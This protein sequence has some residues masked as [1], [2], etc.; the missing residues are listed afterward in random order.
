MQNRIDRLEGL[1]LSLMTN[2]QQAAGPTAAN[3]LLATNLSSSSGQSQNDG[4]NQ[5]IDGEDESETDQVAESLGVM[6]VF[7][8]NT[9]TMYYGEAH[10]AAVLHGIREVRDYFATHKN[11]I[12][13]QIDKVAANRASKPTELNFPGPALLF[14][15]TKP[16]SEAE[17]LSSIPSRYMTDMLVA[18]YFNTF[19]PAL[20]IL[21]LPTFQKQYNKH[22]EN[23]SKTSMVWVGMLFAICRMAMYSYHRDGDEP[24]E[25]QG[26]SLDMAANFRTQMA[27]C[28]ILADYTK[29]HNF[30]IE[31]LIFHLHGEYM[32]QREAD[33]SIWVLVGM[34]AR[35]AMRMGY[36]RDSKWF[37]NITPFQGEMRR[38]VWTFVRQ[39]D[40]LFSF[41]QSLPSMIRIGD[42]DTD[43]PRNIHDDEF[44]EDTKEL[45]P[46][47][48]PTEVTASSYMIAKARLAFGFGR[49]LEYLSNV[50]SSSYEEVM[51][52]DN[53]LREIHES[54]PAHLKYRT[55]QDQCLDPV[56][57]ILSRSNLQIIFHKAQCVLH[58]KFLRPA[59]SNPRYVHSRR[60]CL[61]SAM[62]LLKIQETLHSESGP[63]GRMR[64]TKWYT[65]SLT[66]HDFLLA[67]TVMATDLYSGQERDQRSP[68]SSASSDIY[69]WNM[70]TK[71]D[72]LAALEKSRDIWRELRDESMDAFKA[73][74][75]LT[76]M[77]G[78]LNN[79]S[80]GQPDAQTQSPLKPSAYPDLEPG[81]GVSAADEKQTAAYTLGLLSSGGLSPSSGQPS[82]LPA[83]NGFPAASGQATV[84]ES[85]NGLDA[86]LQPTA[87]NP[88]G[89]NSAQG[90]LLDGLPTSAPSPGQFL[91]GGSFGTWG[92]NDMNLDWDTWDSY[93]QPQSNDPANQLWST[94]LTPQPFTSASPGD[95]TNSNSQTNASNPNI[96]PNLDGLP[97]A[98]SS[99][100]PSAFMGA[101]TG[102]AAS[103]PTWRGF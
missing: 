16:P 58:R 49:V 15:A 4:D 3:A 40:L 28:L 35:L 24:P 85:R 73:S 47:H 57:L 102:G 77:L 7:D 101:P 61:D 60:S 39:S 29:P 10:W 92:N 72:M 50:E 55:M 34:I 76:V 21:H 11:E 95:T 6:K 48:S 1:V 84:F 97:P 89:R 53:G 103:M 90:P 44:D 45:P 25:V 83:S 32:H 14:G 65:Y 96:N 99:D 31:T 22:W 13:Q 37:T 5:M 62:A 59:R 27:H 46:A 80:H 81:S 2:G 88:S 93:M 78:R 52:I 67:A 66:T 54:I 9:K 17:I 18:R 87:T 91:F 63:H 43:L 20:H 12:Q 64:K 41:Q 75:L 23:P 100:S 70:P 79:V 68:S 51:K 38:R 98:A 69:T 19:D 56:N 94:G 30:L 36:H 74:E 86:L 42:S 82:N 26:K 8:N 71:E 33:A